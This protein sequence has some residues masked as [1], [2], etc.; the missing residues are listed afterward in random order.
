MYSTRS[1]RFTREIDA[2]QE[3]TETLHNLLQSHCDIFGGMS[4]AKM[5][6]QSYLIDLIRVVKKS[7]LTMLGCSIA[8]PLNKGWYTKQVLHFTVSGTLQS[9]LHFCSYVRAMTKLV[10]CIQVR[11]DRSTGESFHIA[12]DFCVMLLDKKKSLQL[13]TS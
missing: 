13:E 4:G 8:A 6:L 10:K 11:M 1:T 7:E 9:I 12:F 5:M 3:K 2:L